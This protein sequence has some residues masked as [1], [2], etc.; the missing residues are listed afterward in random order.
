MDTD[1]F[2]AF[3]LGAESGRAVLGRLR[4]G[5]ICLEEIHRFRNEPVSVRGRL[6]WDILWLYNNVLQGLR[7]YVAQYGNSLASMG[8]DSWSVDFG[9]LASDGTLLQNPVHYRDRRTEGMVR[10]A[11][12]HLS[13]ERLFEITGLTVNRVHTVFQLFAMRQT[14]DPILRAAHTL[15]MIPDLIVYFLTGAQCCER[16]NASHTQL[17]NPQTRQWASE[18]FA[19][20]DLPLDIMP[21]LIDPGTPV[22]QLSGAVA[23]E[24]GASTGTVLAPCSH[25]TA[26]AVAAIPAEGQDWAFV[27]CGTW[28]L[29]GTVIPHPVV[30]AEAFAAG[31]MNELGVDSFF[32]C[33]N[34]MG[35]WLLQQA[36]AAWRDRGVSYS[37]EQLID[38]AQQAPAGGPVIDPDAD[39]FVAPDDMVDAIGDYCQ[40]TRQPPVT[41]V[42]A[43]VR[44]ITESLALS[45]R[46]TL[47]QLNE[48]LDR[49]FRALHIVG[50]GCQNTLLCQMAA[51]AVRIPVVAGPVEATAAGNVL[52]QALGLG[53][54]S[55]PEQIRQIVRNSFAVTKY[56]PQDT[57]YMDDQYERYLRVIG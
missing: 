23:E 13:S 15:L 7:K 18:V 42:P 12:R 21:A 16:T 51:D 6:Y 14:D 49:Q 39:C 44:C 53:A 36:R 20:L 10:Q 9:L 31:V 5:R 40:Q 52:V 1:N 50:G 57:G 29:V 4:D 35:L 30:T 22:G 55:S 43:V 8:I 28:S 45:Y 56:E 37:Y 41:D 38:M 3:D 27:S 25:D 26:S 48:I 17:W 19:A 47:E 34:I 2:L 33:R 54:L 32:M 46:H 11:Y 24:T